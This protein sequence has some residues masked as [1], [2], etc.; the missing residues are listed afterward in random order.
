MSLNDSPGF[1]A[2]RKDGT[3][4]PISIHLAPLT[5]SHGVYVVTF[6]TDSHRPA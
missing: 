3:E 5:T 2:V 4:F 1:I 6:V